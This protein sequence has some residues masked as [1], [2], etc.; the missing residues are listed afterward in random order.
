MMRAPGFVRRR[1][2]PPDALS[3]HDIT[4]I[5]QIVEGSGVFV[6]G[7]TIVAGAEMAADSRAVE[8]IVGPSV[9]GTGIRGGTSR[10]VGVG[11]VT[12]R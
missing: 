7:G 10:S 12:T 5:Y 3:Y 11:D 1:R 9:R 8:R 2:T 6:S 4:E